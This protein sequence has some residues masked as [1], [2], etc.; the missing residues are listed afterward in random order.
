M[1]IDLN[2]PVDDLEL[3]VRAMNCL[4]YE[5]IYTIKDLIKKSE[6]QLNKIPNMG[7]K[8]IKE[9]VEQLKINNLHLGMD[10]EVVKFTSVRLNFYTEEFTFSEE[11][12]LKLTF[13]ESGKL[14]SA[15]VL[16]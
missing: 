5:G 11:N 12:N 4:K 2:R 15:E 3:T 9:I 13:N 6:H 14:I 8:T 1:T 7:K 16:K 10:F